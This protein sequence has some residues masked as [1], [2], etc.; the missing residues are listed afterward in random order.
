MNYKLRKSRQN[1]SST[2]KQHKFTPD[3]LSKLIGHKNRHLLLHHPNYP[4][5]HSWNYGPISPWIK[6]LAAA[7][8]GNPQPLIRL[9]RSHAKPDQV[10][11]AEMVAELFFYFA[12][13]FQRRTLKRKRGQQQTPS[14]TWSP[15]NERMIWGHEIMHYSL[16]VKKMTKEEAAEDAARVLDIEGV[17][18]ESLINFDER[19]PAHYWRDNKRLYP[20]K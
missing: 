12:D 15:S 11:S 17:T 5:W 1:N 10:P 4:R 6:A 19:R 14:Y 8:A 2:H 16:H 7:D 9:L 18:T 3:Q 13:L 20:F